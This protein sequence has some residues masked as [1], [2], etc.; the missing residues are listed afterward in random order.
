MPEKLLSL[1]QEPKYWKRQ[2]SPQM[3]HVFTA[4]RLNIKLKLYEFG[5]NQVN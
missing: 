4:I 5:Q 1:E 3:K 2:K